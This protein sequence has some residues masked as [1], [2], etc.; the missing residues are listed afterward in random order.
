MEYKIEHLKAKNSFGINLGDD[1][2]VVEYVVTD[3]TF[4]IIHTIVPKAY[5]GQGIAGKLVTAAYTY[6]KEQGYRLQGSCSYA[7]TWLMRHPDFL[8]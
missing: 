2:A 4:D 7:E 3:N 6:A 8:V 5:S 1:W